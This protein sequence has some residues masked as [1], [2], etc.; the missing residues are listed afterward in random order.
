MATSKESAQL[1]KQSQDAALIGAQLAM[2]RRTPSADIMVARSVTSPNATSILRPNH[3][4]ATPELALRKRSPSEASP[5]PQKG[6]QI[7]E[8]PIPF[9]PLQQA[10]FLVL[11]LA[12]LWIIY[13]HLTLLVYA[14]LCAAVMYTSLHIYLLKSQKEVALKALDTPARS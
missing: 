8:K 2:A 1:G 3:V 6:P 14:S 7:Q 4:S 11:V 10:I 5:K 13:S 9:S 12:T